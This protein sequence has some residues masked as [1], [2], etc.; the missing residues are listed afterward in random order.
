MKKLQDINVIS[1]GPEVRVYMDSPGLWYNLM[2]DGTRIRTKEEMLKCAKEVIDEWDVWSDNP[3]HMVC[4]N[5]LL[6]ELEKLLSDY[7]DNK[8]TL[9]F[10][11][12]DDMSYFLKVHTKYEPHMTLVDFLKLLDTTN[13]QYSLKGAVVTITD[14]DGCIYAFRSTESH[15]GKIIHAVDV[16]KCGWHGICNVMIMELLDLIHYT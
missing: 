9:W 10:I 7:D 16:N 4:C 3:A 8:H 5:D 6:P 15:Y 11:E 13:M 12:D 1:M 14:N 2:Y